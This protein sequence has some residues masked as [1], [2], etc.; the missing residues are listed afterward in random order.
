ML[1]EMVCDLRGKITG[2][3]VIP[4]HEGGMKMEVSTEQTGKVLGVDVMD[5]TT[6]ET[7]MKPGGVL[8]GMGQG[9]TMGKGGEMGMYY[10]NG[11]GKMTG[12]GSGVSF[13]G[14]L[15][16]MSQSP[17]W[18]SLNGAALVFEYEAD[19]NGNVRIKAWEWK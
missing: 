3:R 9:M 19:E 5:M 13:R 1:G 11:V 6:Y 12:K 16:M 4:Y 15:Y 8:F 2:R 7:M 17:K 18:A 10:A 14:A